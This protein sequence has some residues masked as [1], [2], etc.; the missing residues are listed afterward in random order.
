ME[1]NTAE[2]SKEMADA[3]PPSGAEMQERLQYS[4]LWEYLAACDPE[5]E[6]ERAHELKSIVDGMCQQEEEGEDGFR[7]RTDPV[8]GSV[9]FEYLRQIE[10]PDL[11]PVIQCKKVF[12][13]VYLSNGSSLENAIDND[14]DIAGLVDRF[15]HL[16]NVSSE[17]QQKLTRKIQ[18]YR[19]RLVAGM[20]IKG[21]L[22]FA[23]HGAPD[24]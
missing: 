21:E 19:V 3:Y 18:A 8:D 23:K 7:V 16:G 15:V 10:R 13:G 20:I 24:T 11:D 22:S 6:R 17:V 2:G 5:E 12:S 14:Q 9:R 4:S 1:G